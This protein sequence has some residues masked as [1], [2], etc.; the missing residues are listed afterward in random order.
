MFALRADRIAVFYDP[1][2]IEGYREAI[3][4]VPRVNFPVESQPA[5]EFLGLLAGYQLAEI[6]ANAEV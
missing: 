3:D 4:R 6:E 2:Q 5:F 1:E